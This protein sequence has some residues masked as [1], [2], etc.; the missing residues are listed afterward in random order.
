MKAKEKRELFRKNYGEMLLPH[1]FVY[2]K[3]EEI[4]L[5]AH[6]DVALVVRMELFPSGRRSFIR[7]DAMSY[8]NGI[9]WLH[10]KL[11]LC[12]LWAEPPSGLQ[13]YS[14][15]IAQTFL[16]DHET[17]KQI[18]FA[19]ILDRLIRVTNAREAL[20]FHEWEIAFYNTG[21]VPPMLECVAVG[22]Y[23][24]ALECARFDLHAALD[25][26]E[27]AKSTYRPYPLESEP[28]VA[29]RA[30]A[31][32]EQRQRLNEGMEERMKRYAAEVRARRQDVDD[33]EHGRYERLRA[34]ITENVAISR[35][36]LARLGCV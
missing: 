15:E 5:R 6:A 9:R 8:C 13:S 2:C 19:E 12:S 22:A 28:P 34:H 27:R 29:K 21:R 18:F 36:T 23:D 10:P 25:V 33:L 11:I 30:R 24:R 35:E 20:D 1:G 31:T 7:Y 3:K 4:F 16:L 26:Y 14:E 17:Q 32:W